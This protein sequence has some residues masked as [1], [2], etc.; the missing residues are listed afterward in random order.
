MKHHRAVLSM[1]LGLLVALAAA[2]SGGGGAASTSVT[3][4][5]ATTTVPVTT[6]APGP[7]DTVPVPP[8]LLPAGCA[9]ETARDLTT[10]EA[11]LADQPTLAE[12]CAVAGPPDWVE[13]NIGV[14]LY[15]LDDGG[16]IAVAFGGR[17]GLVV[18]AVWQGPDGETRSLIDG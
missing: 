10:F 17:D 13:A 3:I 9:A 1:A 4:A 6:A 11:A 18:Y 12:L 5:A 8:G 16:Q 15:D 7:D 14:L 2:C